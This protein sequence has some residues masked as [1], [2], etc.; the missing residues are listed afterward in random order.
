ML[1]NRVHRHARLPRAVPAK[2]AGRRPGF[3]FTEV[4]FAVM[5]LG[6]GF[7]MI[8][9]IFPVALTQTKLTNEET[10]AA[11]QTRGGV[12]YLEQ[13]ATNANLPATG[14]K[15]AILP[16]AV[17]QAMGGNLIPTS[18][19]RQ[20]LVALYRRQDHWSYAQLVFVP[21]QIRNRPSY[22]PGDDAPS[23]TPAS[24]YARPVRLAGDPLNQV[25]LLSSAGDGTAPQAAAEGCYL[26]IAEHPAA[27][28]IPPNYLG[29]HVYRLGTRGTGANRWNLMPG[30]DIQRE[31]GPDGQL[32]GAGAADDV[33]NF[34]ANTVAFLVGKGALDVG[35]TSVE[36]PAQD[37]S[38]Y[39]T[40][41]NLR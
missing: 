41:I 6:I 1:M 2:T 19:P 3:S 33:T 37:V 5:I 10:A 18:D 11:M 7:I 16:P 30:W 38:A 26:V 39:T 17:V 9:A 27:G 36:G 25:V 15:V 23:A 35:G 32:G 24:F 40:F 34:P 28:P 12:Q 21:V 8:A 22:K 20:A 31:P 13:Y 14:G 4:L 29:G